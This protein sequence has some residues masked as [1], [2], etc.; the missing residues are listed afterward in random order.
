MFPIKCEIFSQ[1]S[2]PI[3]ILVPR[4]T[5]RSSVSIENF[6]DCD[7]LQVDLGRLLSRFYLQ[8]R[9]MVHV[10]GAES[11]NTSVNDRP[12]CPSH[13]D[14]IVRVVAY[15]KCRRSETVCCVPFRYPP[16]LT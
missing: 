1:T 13:I 15:R 3:V 2:L 10:N 9:F 5:F 16:I 8:T 7:S 14:V 12:S 4:H 6:S 11:S